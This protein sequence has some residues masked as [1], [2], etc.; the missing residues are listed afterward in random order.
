MHVLQLDRV[1]SELA[2]D[3]FIHVHQLAFKA[4]EAVV[5]HRIVI[6]AQNHIA[7][8]QQIAH[9]ALGLHISDH[10]AHAITAGAERLGLCRI[11]NGEIARREIDIV[12]VAAVFDVLEEAF[13]H[14]HWNHVAHVLRH[15]AAEALEGHTDDFAFLQHR[16][17]G[18]AGIDRG[19]HLNRQ[20]RVHAGMAVRAEVDA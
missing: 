18:V 10:H 1:A 15:P 8:L 9:A 17:A 20:M 12:V 4:H 6:N 11:L 3:D 13:D 16:P 7:N 5:H 19:I 2:L 14:R